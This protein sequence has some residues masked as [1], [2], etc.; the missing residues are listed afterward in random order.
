MG[1]N[2]TTA[3]W[4]FAVALIAAAFAFTLWQRADD[5]AE[6]SGESPD[7]GSAYVALGVAGV[8]AICGTI[9]YATSSPDEGDPP[10]RDPDPP[11]PPMP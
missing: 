2:R 8:A 7:R 5:D 4:I 1:G 3:T 6:F 10:P 11:A 9:V